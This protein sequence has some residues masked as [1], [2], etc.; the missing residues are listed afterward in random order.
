MFTGLSSVKWWPGAKVGGRTWCDL[1][2]RVKDTT[3]YRCLALG[4]LQGYADTRPAPLGPA[5]VSRAFHRPHTFRTLD[6]QLNIL[7]IFMITGYTLLLSN[8][9]ECRSN[10]TFPY[11]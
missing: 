7:A 3:N 1:S 4:R 11:C 6:C 5:R 8:V 9:F 2:G 10:I